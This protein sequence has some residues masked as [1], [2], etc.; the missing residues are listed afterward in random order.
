MLRLLAS[1][2]VCL[3]V[4]Q[5]P[6]TK[7]TC[8]SV[9]YRPGLY[10]DVEA[11]CQVSGATATEPSEPRVTSQG[12]SFLEKVGGAKCHISKLLFM[13]LSKSNTFDTSKPVKFEDIVDYS[14]SEAKPH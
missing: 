4:W 6:E 13:I 9:P 12:W 14:L 10:A 8:D 7:F 5:V 11:G 3:C 1:H 2:C